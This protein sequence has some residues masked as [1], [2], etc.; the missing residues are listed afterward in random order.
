M[1]K[2]I[3]TD[4]NELDEYLE[5]VNAAFLTKN[6]IEKNI[7]GQ[8]IVN[9]YDKSNPVYKY[10]HSYS[11]A[12][13]LAINYDG[14][15]DK[16]GYYTHLNEIFDLINVSPKKQVLEL[17]CGKGFNSIYLAKKIPQAQFSGIDITNNHLKI[18]QRK[19]RDI[20]NLKF[21][22]GDFHKLDF[23]DSSFD[24][25]FELEAICHAHD[26]MQVLSEIYRTLKKGGQ[27]VLYDGFR[28]TGFENLPE[29][30]IRAAIL[31]EK[32]LAVEGFE[33]IDQWLQMAE[34]AGFK[35]KAKKDLSQDVM[36]TLGKLQLLSRKYFEFPF[37]SKMFLKLFPQDM[38]M[39]TIAV[40]LMPFTMQN[41]AHCYYKIILEK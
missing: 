36:P 18:A 22:Y 16:K 41:K 6:I 28:Q 40:L 37:L 26:S 35:L 39:N 4:L 25:I 29:N 31:T 14:K 32:S 8:F 27:F 7:D 5:K 33:R 24:F 3:V 21:T 10:I 19:S 9:Y 15:F 30:L 12:V 17:G 38:M 23:A 1:N 2:N 34:K 20:E 11:G 13:H